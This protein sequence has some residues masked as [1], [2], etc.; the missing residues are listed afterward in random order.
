MANNKVLQAVVEIAGNIS[1]TLQKAV[2]GAAGKLDK[3][4]LKAAAV[5]AAAAAGAVAVG[6]A[7]IEA[8]KY[9]VDLGSQFDEATDSI[10][11]VTGATGDA[12][13]SLMEDFDAVYS[14]V[15]TTMEDASKAIADYNTRLGLTGPALQ[16]ISKQA[17]QVAD[18]LGEDLGTVIESSSEAFQQWDIAAE[19]MGDAMDYVFKASQSTGVG[20]SELMSSVQTYGAQ[21][22]EMGYSFEEATALIGQLEKAGVN[23]NEVLSAMKKSV[24]SLAKEGINASDGLEMYFEAISNAKDMTEA[25][26]IATEIFGSKAA[27]TMAAAIRDGTVDVAALTAELEANGETITGCAE[28][29]YDFAERLQVFKQKAQVALEP[30]ASTLFDSLNELMPVVGSLMDSLIPIIQ[31]LTATLTPLIADLVAKIGP[32]L[33]EI[34]PIIVEVAGS[35]AADLIPPIVEIISSI[36]PVLIELLQTVVPILSTLIKS[37]LPIVVQLINKLLPPILK[38][39]EAVL[40]VVIELLNAVLPLLDQLLSAILPVIIQLIETLLPL[41]MTIID[42]VLPIVIEL[43]NTIVPILTQILSAIL[44]VIIELINVLVP[45]LQTIIEAV[46]PILIEVLNLLTPILDLII[47]LLQ[48]ILD[49]FIMLLEPILSLISSAIQ[50]LIDIF[51]TLISAI[52]EPI[53]PILQFLASLFTDVL[54]GA[55]AGIQPIISALTDVFGGLIDFITGIFS[56]NWSQAWDGIVGIFKGIFNLI[57]SVVEFVINGAIGIINGII[58]G[59][60]SVSKYVGLEIGLIPE[61]HLPRFAEGGFTDGLSIAGEEGVEAVISFDPAFREANIGYWIEAGERLGTISKPTAPEGVEGI[62][63]VTGLKFYASGGFTDGVT[64]AGEAGT[65]AVIS[66]D[67]RYHDE[68]V[69]YWIEAGEKLGAFS[70]LAELNTASVIEATG[71]QPAQ[72]DIPRFAEGGFT[73]GLSIAGEEGVEA[74]ISFDPAFREANIGYWIEAGER[75]G[76]ISKPTAPEGVEG[77]EGVTGL[78]FYASGGFTDGVTIAG[79][80]GTEAVIS[81]DPRYHDENVRYWIEA[82]EKLGAFSYLAELNTASVIEATGAQPAQIDIPRFAEGGFTDGLSI[83]G[84]EGVEAV[85][86]FDPANRTQNTAVWAKAGKL[87]GVLHDLNVETGAEVASVASLQLIKDEEAASEEP[88][89]AQAGKLADLDGFS[90][91]ELTETTIIYYDFSGFT[92]SPQVEAG[93]AK[94]SDDILAKLR[95]EENEFFDWLEEWLRQKEVGAYDRI[96]IY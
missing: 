84:E 36:I 15:P 39:I 5:G 46:L 92:W 3:I 16:N 59:I 86:S 58:S 26:T 18:M 23:T 56:G 27:S 43:L 19:D 66:F 29:T 30:L 91:G 48:P 67:P 50:P 12:L 77:I 8:G 64:I 96:S 60:N 79:E 25:T 6:K 73:D 1:P 10:R 49:L 11:I 90:L 24:G 81:F 95:E 35:F 44:P 62:E 17:I 21:M 75:L 80:A 65:E 94:D 13:D 38:V 20:F 32:M 83:A 42:A 87:L 2:E 74:V 22:Q 9:L 72:I 52:L 78:K 69:R 76:T 93:S 71:A 88:L 70:Y 54:G 33:E 57:P 28:D 45:I 34:V 47:A 14:S 40:P 51:S 41:V 82:G 7:A 85:I 53:Q 61:V 89:I 68:N 37:V 4:N 55:I 31:N 63:G